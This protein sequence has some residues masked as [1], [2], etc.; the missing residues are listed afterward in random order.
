MILLLGIMDLL[1]ATWII[2]A[3]FGL[4][5]YGSSVVFIIYLMSKLLMF[6][7]WISAMDFLA[8]I[9]L[10]AIFYGLHTFLAWI[11][12]AYLAQKA[13]SSLLRF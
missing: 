2:L 6:R 11:F 8:A 7:D 5:G 4:V 1:A 13:I 10:L 3:H 9:Y 12:A